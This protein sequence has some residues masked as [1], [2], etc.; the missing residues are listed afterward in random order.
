MSK[1]SL[2]ATGYARCELLHQQFLQRV[3]QQAL[4]PSSSVLLSEVGLSSSKVIEIFT[5][6]LVSRHLDY[7]ARKLK[8]DNK[9]YYTIGSVGHEGSAA[10]AGAFRLT[11]M[12]FLHYRSGAFMVQRAS[13][14]PELDP[15]HDILA[16]LMALKLDPIAQGRHK[17]FGHSK[18]YVPPQTSTIASHLP[19]ALGVAVSIK[20][21][22]TLKL[23]SPLPYDSVVLCSFGDASVNHAVALS[24]FNTAEW[25]VRHHY[26]L[27]MVFIC[28]DN[29]L[30]VSV[31]TPQDWIERQYSNRSYL[32]YLS[33]DGHDVM[34]VYA[35]AK[36][37]EKI[38][39][40][41]KRPVF[42]HI[43]CVR[44][45]GHAGVDYEL[46]YRLL[47]E[48]LRDESNDPLLYSASTLID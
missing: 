1:P 17:V 5:S 31:K 28:E 4:P 46:D 32:H 38:A 15:I 18:L 36:K 40:H 27:P 6:Q 43:K 16:S 37:A 48:V 42:L 9:S 2:F 21:A 3:Q 12:A 10:I 33:V 19:K 22:Q 41:E 29:G 8:Q 11:D 14:L 25:I 26:P 34:A 7:A 13:F 20:R 24:A 35:A 47:E 45:L 39:R 30:G 23:E 44:L